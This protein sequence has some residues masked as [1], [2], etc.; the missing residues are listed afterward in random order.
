MQHPLSFEQEL[1][2]TVGVIGPA[3]DEDLGI[4]KV[5]A[6]REQERQR[7]NLLDLAAENLHH[8]MLLRVS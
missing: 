4:H 5:N 2:Q 3:S 1:H 7:V 6:I 8:L